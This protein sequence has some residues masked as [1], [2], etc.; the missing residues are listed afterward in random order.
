MTRIILSMM[1][2]FFLS[3]CPGSSG[4]LMNTRA[5]DL[6]FVVDTDPIYVRAD[7]G[8]VR[9][10][11]NGQGRFLV[12]P[13]KYSFLTV[14]PNHSVWAFGDS[15]TNLYLLYEP[16]GQLHRIPELDNRN[17]AV[18]ISPDG[19]RIAATR[20]SDFDLPQSRQVDDD[21]IYL[22]DAATRRV[23]VLE[24]KNPVWL[25]QL[26]WSREQPVLY[27]SGHDARYAIHLETNERQVIELIPMDDTFPRFESRRTCPETGTT[28]V[29]N[30]DSGLDVQSADG[31]QEP[32]VIIEGRS[33][34]FHDYHATINDFFFS[35]SCNF[36]V[37]TFEGKVWVVEVS[38]GLVHPI[39]TGREPRVI[40]KYL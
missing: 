3:G 15:D 2:L 28:L 9:V 39:I 37:F 22:I 25:F 8:L 7:D 21:R 5:D 30:G 38:T 14:A 12:A 4:T 13:S 40:P 23:E 19:S 29:A 32:L 33:R 17:S 36:A 6:S 10:N 26:Y 24:A 35:E 11:I 1:A 20:H 34:G 18:A 31:T 27:G 16:G